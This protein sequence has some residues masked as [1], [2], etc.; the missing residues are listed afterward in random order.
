[1][2][3]WIGWIEQTNKTGYYRPCY[4]GRE[5][6]IPS[7]FYLGGGGFIIPLDTPT[8]LPKE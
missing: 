6:D 2:D 1:M 7:V 5:I 4:L 3:E 8:Y